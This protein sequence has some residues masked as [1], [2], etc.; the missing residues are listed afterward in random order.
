[1][2]DRHPKG[3]PLTTMVLNVTSKCNLACTYCYEYGED[4]IVEQST[5]PRFMDE[6]TARESVDFM[7]AQ[8]GRTHNR[9][10]LDRA[11][12]RVR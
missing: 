8:A 3:F 12:V 5:T 1:M 7:F 6:E 2:E 11:R 9:M 10:G 4:A